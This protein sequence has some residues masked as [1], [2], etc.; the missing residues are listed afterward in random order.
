MGV[1]SS[2]IMIL[3]HFLIYIGIFFSFLVLKI[4]SRT[5][6]MIHKHFTTNLYSQ[7]S[8][9]LFILR[10]YLIKLSKLAHSEADTGSEFCDPFAQL[11]W[12][13]VK[14]LFI[15]VFI[16]VWC[17]H[18][19][20]FYVSLKINLTNDYKIPSNQQLSDMGRRNGELYSHHCLVAILHRAASCLQ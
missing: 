12:A 5:S 15:Y 9:S 6:S 16:F 18:F 1:L 3:E 4:E 8:F 19:Y 20:T 13:T 2:M 17:V 7:T 11:V 14:I 10:E